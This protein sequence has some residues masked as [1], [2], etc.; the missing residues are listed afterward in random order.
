MKFLPAPESNEFPEQTLGSQLLLDQAPRLLLDGI[1]QHYTNAYFDV[2]SLE[3]AKQLQSLSEAFRL[4]SNT[5][6][7]EGMGASFEC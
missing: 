3:Y 5:R 1:D 7:I 2:I 6:W 4:D